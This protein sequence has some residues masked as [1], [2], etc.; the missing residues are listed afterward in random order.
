VPRQD[1]QDDLVEPRQ[2]ARPPTTRTGIHRGAELAPDAEGGAVA[3]ID[4]AQ[5]LAGAVR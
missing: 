4:L 1:G 5:Q 2:A 3:P